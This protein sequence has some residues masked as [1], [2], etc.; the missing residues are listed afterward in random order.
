MQI[1]ASENVDTKI[2]I[3]LFEI[4]RDKFQLRMV[5][6]KAHGLVKVF[7]PALKKN[8]E[9]ELPLV[10]DLLKERQPKDRTSKV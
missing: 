3:P 7:H 9:D 8:R 4:G 5:H 1:M 6:C 2:A 10:C